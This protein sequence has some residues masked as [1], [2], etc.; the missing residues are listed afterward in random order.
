MFE[1]ILVVT[2]DTICGTDLQLAGQDLKD[3]IDDINIFESIH[4]TKN[5]ITFEKIIFNQI[6]LFNA[7]VFDF[8]G[9]NYHVSPSQP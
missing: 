5:R 8:E 2:V 1:W 3:N 9:S 7:N 4:N 6:D